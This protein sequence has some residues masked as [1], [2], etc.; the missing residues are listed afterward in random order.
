VLVLGSSES[1]GESSDL[2]TLTDR[3]NKFY[4]SRPAPLSTTVHGF[5]VGLGVGLGVGASTTRT[6]GDR[7]ARG[8]LRPMISIAHLADRKILEQYAPPGVASPPRR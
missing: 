8:T 3:K 2:F 4:V 1:I 5:G 7:L 6:T